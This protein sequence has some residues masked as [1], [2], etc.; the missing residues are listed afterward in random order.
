MTDRSDRIGDG[1]QQHFERVADRVVAGGDLCGRVVRDDFIDRPR[2]LR[3]AVAV[4]GSAAELGPAAPGPGGRRGGDEGN[5]APAALRAR[6]LLATLPAPEG[7]RFCRNRLWALF[8]VCCQVAELAASACSLTVSCQVRL[9][10]SS[11][12]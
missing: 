9:I 10:C 3:L 11:I 5:E 6:T 4:S 7:R 12:P 2:G 1:R 8:T